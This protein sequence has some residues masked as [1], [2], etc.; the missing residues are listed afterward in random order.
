MEKQCASNTV[1]PEFLLQMIEEMAT[2]INV[3]NLDKIIVKA[4]A[5]DVELNVRHLSHCLINVAFSKTF[6]DKQILELN[7]WEN[8]LLTNM[9]IKISEDLVKEHLVLVFT[10]HAYDL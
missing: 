10:Q 8:E 1:S 6:F 7:K 2:Y 9:L 3:D 5:A 4:R